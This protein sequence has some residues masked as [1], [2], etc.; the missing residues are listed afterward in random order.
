MRDALKAR[1]SDM[2]EKMLKLAE[3][4]PEDRYESRPTD[5][6]RTFADQ[7]RHVAFW[8]FYVADVLR[9]KDANGDA[10]E[11]PRDAYPTKAKVV[12]ALRSSFDAVTAQLANG[13]GS[14]DLN[15]VV[16]FIEHNGEHYG[17][18]VVYARLNGMVPP[19]SR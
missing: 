8:N 3:E 16:A 6:V 5:A 7:L 12:G 10:N 11:L 18:L 17:Q 19:A 4:F 14:T 13:N 2:G 9:H 15:Q 1:W